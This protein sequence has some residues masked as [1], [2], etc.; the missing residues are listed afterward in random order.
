MPTALSLDGPL[1]RIVDN[2][3]EFEH[4][5]QEIEQYDYLMENSATAAETR[6]YENIKIKDMATIHFLHW[7]KSFHFQ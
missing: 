5:V 6:K 1:H 3:S 2:E 7:N 4:F